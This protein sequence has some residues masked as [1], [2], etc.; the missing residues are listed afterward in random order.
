[1]NS[2]PVSEEIQVIRGVNHTSSSSV[3][4]KEEG[5]T[6]S[7]IAQHSSDSSKS[8]S[9][10]FTG[11]PETCRTEMIRSEG[12]Y[13]QLE[14]TGPVASAREHREV[15]M[16]QQVNPICTPLWVCGNFRS[17]AARSKNNIPCS[18]C[19]RNRQGVSPFDR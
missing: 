15:V 6:M 1:M 14:V 13:R 12:Q 18:E 10:L 4:Q 5:Y 3:L 2:E 8:S 17:E 9:A 11:I 16:G 19:K 7:G